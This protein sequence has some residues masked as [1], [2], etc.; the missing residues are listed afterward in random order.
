MGFTPIGEKS[1]RQMV[2][3]LIAEVGADEIVTYEQ[4]AEAIGLTW[5]KDREM[6]RSTIHAARSSLANDH[7]KALAAVRGVGY[8]VIRPE[9][10]VH[11]A[12]Q[13]QRKAGRSVALAK[14]TIDTVDLGALDDQQRQLALAARS[15]LA[16]QQETLRRLDLRQRGLEKVVG[17]VTEKVDE[18]I[19]KTDAHQQR[20]ADL[21]RRIA[22]LEGD[23]K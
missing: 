9:E 8:R 2:V 15:V 19:A 12:A 14:T 20:L 3:E 1:R 23:D 22:E 16:Y 6:V 11:I 17:S 5:P 18:T 21:E 7:H 13:L 10:H 4:V